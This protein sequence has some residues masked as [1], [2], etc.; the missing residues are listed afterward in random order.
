[1][2]MMTDASSLFMLTSTMTAALQD[3]D[4]DEQQPATTEFAGKRLLRWGGGEVGSRGAEA[5]GTIF[6]VWVL[7]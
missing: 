5:E 3:D 4:D 2:V 1:M 7:I 6:R